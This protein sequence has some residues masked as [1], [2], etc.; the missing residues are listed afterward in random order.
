MT[1]T[2]MA[3]EFATNVMKIQKHQAAL[4]TKAGAKLTVLVQRMTSHVKISEQEKFV[5]TMENVSVANVYVKA[6]MTV[7]N[8]VKK[9]LNSWIFVNS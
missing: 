2:A 3:M 5:L 8:I 7:E 1:R 6:D 9:A 4:V